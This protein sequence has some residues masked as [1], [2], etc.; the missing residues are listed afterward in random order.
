MLYPTGGM[1]LA[2]SRVQIKP[3][4]SIFYAFLP[5]R[6]IKSVSSLTSDDPTVEKNC[7]LP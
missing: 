3:N 4:W 6:S 5:W 2:P 1:V 7:P